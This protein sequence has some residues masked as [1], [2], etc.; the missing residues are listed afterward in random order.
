MSTHLAPDAIATKAGA[1]ARFIDWLGGLPDPWPALR[2][3]AEQYQYFS[4]HQIRA[5]SQII[6]RLPPTDRAAAS[7]VASVLHDELGRGQP[8]E[9]HSV[10]FENFARSVGVDVA[11]LPLQRA[12]LVAG[13]RMYV[14]ELFDAFGPD[15]TIA[16]AL[17]TYLFLE[18]SAVS[19]YAPMLEVLRRPRFEGVDLTFF[20][21]HAVMEVEHERAAAALVDR[22]VSAAAEA[23]AARDRQ[24]ARMAALWEA[25]WTDVHAHCAGAVTPVG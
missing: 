10:L 3:Y 13:V 23:V 9:V 5:F 15:T 12:D 7:L 22:Y 19:T 1:E 4:L 25:F 11:R 20:E 17:A 8:D 21:L 18:R 6:L 2:R 16:R 24:M 14:D